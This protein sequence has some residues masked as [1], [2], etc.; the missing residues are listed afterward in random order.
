MPSAVPSV[1]PVRGEARPLTAAHKSRMER[2]RAKG[3]AIALIL[4]VMRGLTAWRASEP[5]CASDVAE[6]ER[7]AGALA[8]AGREDWMM[9][10]SSHAPDGTSSAAKPGTR[11]SGTHCSRLCNGC[12]A[13]GDEV[14]ADQNGSGLERKRSGR[15]IG[16]PFDGR[17]GWGGP[18]WARRASTPIWSSYQ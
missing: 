7:P 1:H 2:M 4:F 16:A 3:H 13:T 17:G 12:S 14:T 8:K 18:N 10:R 6:P 11:C 15:P 5:F 9:S